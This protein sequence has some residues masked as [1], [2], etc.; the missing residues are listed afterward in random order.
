MSP[1][2]QRHACELRTLRRSS[3]ACEQ[4]YHNNFTHAHFDILS[5][6]DTITKRR[7]HT[8]TTTREFE[9]EPHSVPPKEARA[10]ERVL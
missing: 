8:R 9:D 1:K 3:T 7:T 5:E 4:Y 2:N 10:D 6:S